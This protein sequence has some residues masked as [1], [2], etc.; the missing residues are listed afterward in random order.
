[1]SVQVD[2]ERRHHKEMDRSRCGVYRVG[3]KCL[4]SQSQL[5]ASRS[6]SGVSVFPPETW[7]VP[8]RLGKIKIACIKVHAHSECQVNYNYHD[9][10]MFCSFQFRLLG[11]EQR[12]C[13]S[14][15][16]NLACRLPPVICFLK[17]RNVALF[18]SWNYRVSTRCQA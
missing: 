4:L 10:Y 9:K 6:L 15:T 5:R 17:K 14:S 3:F 13:A 12:T 2:E 16:L 7:H 18:I 8:G 11:C 1:M